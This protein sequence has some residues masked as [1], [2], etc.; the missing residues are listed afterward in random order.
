MGLPLLGIVG[1]VFR[2]IFGVVD[3]MVEDKDKA[4][5][6]KVKLAEMQTQL[7]SQLL[8]TQTV[9]WVDATVKILMAV[10]DLV[11]PLFRPVFGAAL[12]GLAV[13][14][15]YKGVPINPTLQAIMAAAFPG[16]MVGRQVKK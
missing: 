12:T 13:W 15:E 2:G 14:F 16:W 3:Q 4:A 10:R 1:E 6:L 9:P 7:N 5:E 8:T 11:I